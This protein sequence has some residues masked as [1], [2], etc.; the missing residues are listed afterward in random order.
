M[1]FVSKFFLPTILVSLWV[2]ILMLIISLAIDIIT[3]K[4]PESSFSVTHRAPHVWDLKNVA[5]WKEIEGD[6]L[7]EMEWKKEN[8]I[9]EMYD[10]H[11]FRFSDQIREALED[12]EE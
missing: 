6:I 7:K 3:H 12:L 2:C 11:V 9:P 5:E 10:M 1:N 8:L 4:P